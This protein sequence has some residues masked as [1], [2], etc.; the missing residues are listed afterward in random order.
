V[1]TAALIGCGDVSSIHLEAIAAL[2]WT[3]P[4]RLCPYPD[5]PTTD[6]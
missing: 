2:D 6:S 5:S 3:R 4:R 1:A